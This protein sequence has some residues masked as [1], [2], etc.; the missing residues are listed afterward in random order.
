MTLF[1][2]NLDS[3]LIDELSSYLT[4]PN[5]FVNYKTEFTDAYNSFF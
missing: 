2:N 3:T 4:K 5:E 1:L